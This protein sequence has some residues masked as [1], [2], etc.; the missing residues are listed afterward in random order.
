MA[1]L[2]LN[3]STRRTKTRRT[4]KRRRLEVRKLEK[5]LEMIGKK[6]FV[7]YCKHKSNDVLEN[8]ESSDG[9]KGSEFFQ[10]SISQVGLR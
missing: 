1:P 10:S 4:K 9:L 7:K 6:N 5:Y 3:S 2:Q 8:D